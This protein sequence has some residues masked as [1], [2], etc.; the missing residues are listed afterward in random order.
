MFFAQNICIK[1]RYVSLWNCSRELPLAAPLGSPLCS[2]HILQYIPCLILI[3]IQY[4]YEIVE[5]ADKVGSVFSFY[6]SSQNLPRF[7]IKLRICHKS[8]NV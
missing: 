8:W 2:G 3:Q 5:S 7:T 6:L 1:K 4:N